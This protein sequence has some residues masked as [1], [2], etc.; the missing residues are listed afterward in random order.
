MGTETK[1]VNGRLVTKGMYTKIHGK[2]KKE[3]A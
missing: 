1:Q 2:I 3:G